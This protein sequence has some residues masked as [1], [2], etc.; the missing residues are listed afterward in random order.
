M[1][2]LKS[3]DVWLFLAINNLPHDQILVAFFALL[4]GIGTYGFVWL[5]IGIFLVWWEGKNRKGIYELMIACA[6]SL[7][8]T[9]YLIKPLI[10]RV[11][12]EYVLSFSYLI[13]QTSTFSFPSTHA[14]VAF[15][16]SWILSHRH[17]RWKVLVYLLA[18]LI[19]FSRIYLGKHY[20]SDVVF[21]AMM[22]ICI[23]IISEKLFRLL[24]KK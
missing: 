9:E 24:T 18:F 7:V 16:S 3:L 20:P 14:T 23:G 19:A 1:L 21:G 17:P 10:H 5:I 6:I 4:S 8:S 13:D 2:F 12:P 22:G 11:R 15:A